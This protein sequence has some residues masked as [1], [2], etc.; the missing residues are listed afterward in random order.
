M[1]AS[2]EEL[3]NSPQRFSILMNTYEFSY[4]CTLRSVSQHGN[5][6]MIIVSSLHMTQ[7]EG[8]KQ[9]STIYQN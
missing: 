1:A 9:F 4:F 8:K 7:L 3:L 6:I 5:Y 2:E